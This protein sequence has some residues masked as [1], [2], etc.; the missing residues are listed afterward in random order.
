MSD[1]DIRVQMF[2]N[3]Q[4]D[5]CGQPVVLGEGRNSKIILALQVLI[6]H[7]PHK[8][9][10]DL[11]LEIL[12]SDGESA[13]PSANLRV[14]MFRLKQFLKNTPLHNY[15]TICG[16]ANYRWLECTVPL[17]VDAIDFQRLYVQACQS[18]ESSAGLSLFQEA[19]KLYLDDFLR[20]SAVNNWIQ[21]VQ[22]SLQQKYLSCVD[23]LIHLLRKKEQWATLYP[24]VLKA[25]NMHPME[26]FYC[27][28]IDCLLAQNQY[29]DAKQ[30]YLKATHV[31][32]DELSVAPSQ[33]LLDHANQID[34]FLLD[35][36][37]TI[38]DLQQRLCETEQ[39]HG[40]YYCSPSSFVDVFRMVCRMAERSNT[41]A[42][43]MLYSFSDFHGRS[44]ADSSKIS[45]AGS[46][47]R[48]ALQN[49]LRRGD[50]FTQYRSGQYIVLLT[51]TSSNGFFIVHKRICEY[52]HNHPVR[53]VHLRCIQKNVNSSFFQS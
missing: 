45:L 9:S 34:Q 33:A 50:T 19:E 10:R 15:F 21:S 22:A 25:C 44:I 36:H 46:S 13:D 31:L 52:Y 4:V 3:F 1:T 5:V 41:S 30:L 47:L 27:V 14:I 39:A 11:L 28:G 16:N 48:E 43:L 18:E 38:Y 51:N 32:R 53:G 37:E 42:C 29:R 7:Y 40:P 35:G 26:Y 6:Y 24:I 17:F 8:V 12:F 20:F 49:C 2:G 23:N